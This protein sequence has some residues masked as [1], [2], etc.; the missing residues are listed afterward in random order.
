MSPTEPAPRIPLF[1]GRTIKV[2]QEEDFI[3]FRALRGHRLTSPKSAG[4]FFLPEGAIFTVAVVPASQPEWAAL[5]VHG[6]FRS[7]QLP[8]D[9]EFAPLATEDA[10]AIAALLTEKL[11]LP[12]RYQAI[13]PYR[14]RQT[15]PSQLESGAYVRVVGRYD[16]SG[17]FEGPNFEGVQLRADAAERAGLVPGQ[18]YAVT[19]YYSRGLSDG[20]PRPTGY[21]GPSLSVRTI[22]PEPAGSRLA[23]GKRYE[24]PSSPFR[25]GPVWAWLHRPESRGYEQLEFSTRLDENTRFIAALDGQGGDCTGDWAARVSLRTLATLL[26]EPFYGPPIEAPTEPTPEPRDDFDAWVAWLVDRSP[27]PS[28]PVALL[29]AVG[30]RIG[31][32]LEELNLRGYSLGLSGVL[33]LIQGSRV[34]LLRRG[35]SRAY[36]LRRGQLQVLLYEDTLARHPS[37]ATDPAALEALGSAGSALVSLFTPQDFIRCQPPLEFEVEPGDRLIFPL[38]GPLLKALADPARER[39]LAG[40]EPN[41]SAGMPPTRDMDLGGWGVV[42]VEIPPRQAERP[43]SA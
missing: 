41:V 3:G 19:G 29:N 13:Y 30:M 32:V 42:S 35:S 6:D 1:E 18:R 33:A 12:R 2:F 14:L 36:L 23:A 39:L 16:P 25:R 26:P 28:E 8:D 40:Q 27:L 31:L 5:Q 17:H 7:G 10:A 11:K 9:I 20:D 4:T 34:T 24:P 21:S 38:G 43:E 22:R 37:I 15:G